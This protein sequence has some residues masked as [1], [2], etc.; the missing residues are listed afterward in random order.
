MRV[1]VLGFA[2]CHF[3]D[4]QEGGGGVDV[5]SSFVAGSR[6]QKPETTI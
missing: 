4:F 1:L 5:E 3:A 6:L 2:V